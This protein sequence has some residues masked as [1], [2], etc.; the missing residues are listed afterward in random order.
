MS[1]IIP[2]YERPI[3]QRRLSQVLYNRGMD[4]CK[5]PVILAVI[6]GFHREQFN[7]DK[8]NKENRDKFDDAFVWIIKNRGFFTFLGNADPS[9]IKK[10]VATLK[11]GTWQYKIGIHNGT[12]AQKAFIQ[13]E[14]VTVLRDNGDGTQREDGPWWFGINI[15]MGSTNTTSSNGCLTIL[16]EEWELFRNLG[17]AF[18][19]KYNVEKFPVVVLNVEEYEA[20]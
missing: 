8:N 14:P 7:Y 10:D 6:K 9:D 18:L 17:Y 12:T 1:K 16:Y 20:Q 5:T 2:K 13:A 15:H 11:I 3:D 4:I 19:K